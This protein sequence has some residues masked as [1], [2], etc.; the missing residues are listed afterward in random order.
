MCIRDRPEPGCD[1]KSWSH[2]TPTTGLITA[3]S[4]SATISTTE[5]A[6]KSKAA[7]Q[8]AI[9]E[10][11][12]LSVDCSKGPIEPIGSWNVSA[13]IDM[14]WLFYNSVPGAKTFRGDISKWDVSRVTDMAE[15]FS[16]A[17][18]FNGDLSKWDVSSVTSMNN[19][20]FGSKSFNADVS[21]WDVS[22]VA[23]MTGMF[24]RTKV[25]NIDISK[26]NVLHVTSMDKMF[27]HAASFNQ[28]LCGAGWVDA[29]SSKR[30]M[31]TG[32]LGSIS[33]TVCTAAT[34]PFL[35]KAEL[36][37]AVDECLKL[38]PSGDD[39]SNGPH[40]SIAKWDVSRVT[41]IT[42]MFMRV[43]SFNACL[44]YTSPSPRD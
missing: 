44:L 4:T 30:N 28:K 21:S 6:P 13:V 37:Y 11:L 8:A 25:F 20:F 23:D 22:S 3:M 15:M 24:S 16:S 7:L 35:S 26:W 5:W 29:K 33:R 39:C 42:F 43:T 2:N 41:D 17:P 10:C 12:Q 14:S 27:F 38:S 9:G 31:F 34:E 40:G 1:P 18:L 32:S 36:K 19:M